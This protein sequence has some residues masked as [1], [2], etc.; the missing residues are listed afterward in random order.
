MSERSTDAPKSG[1][2]LDCLP[3][4]RSQQDLDSLTHCLANAIFDVRQRLGIEFVIMV[5]HPAIQSGCAISSITDPEVLRLVFERSQQTLQQA[6]SG[7]K[8]DS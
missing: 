4:I 1:G 2:S 3:P 8:L 6:P 5:H 7:G